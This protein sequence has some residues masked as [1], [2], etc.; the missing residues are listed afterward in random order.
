[1][2]LLQ[3]EAMDRFLH[4][5]GSLFWKPFLQRNERTSIVSEN[6]TRLL[7]KERCILRLPDIVPIE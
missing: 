5:I 1:M 6:F 3:V 7:K 2:P 4:V